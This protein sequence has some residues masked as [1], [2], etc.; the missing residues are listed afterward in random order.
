VRLVPTDPGV[1]CDTG[2]YKSWQGF[3]AFIVAVDIVAAPLCL[4]AFLFQYRGRIRSK[5]ATFVALHGIFF[6]QF[7]E[8]AF[9]WQC[10]ILVRR[11]ALSAINV[12]AAA[13]VRFMAFTVAALLCF[14][15][16]VFVMPFRDSVM[17]RMETAGLFI[18]VLVAA[19]LTGYAKAVPNGAQVIVSLLVTIPAVGLLLLV[20]YSMIQSRRA[21]N[22][23]KASD[24]SQTELSGQQDTA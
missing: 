14:S 16:H 1:H 19:I 18:H 6:E 8:E 10:V 20:A 21:K 17:N 13:E 15:M 12:I 11:A 3:M 7:N 22:N 5:D 2:E 24:T 23:K 9:G 4:G